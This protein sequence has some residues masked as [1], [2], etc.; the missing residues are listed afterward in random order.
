MA[1]EINTKSPLS[2][3]IPLGLCGCGCGQT[4]SLFKETDRKR[5]H[6]KGQPARFIAGHNVM[7]G[8]SNHLWKGGKSTH[9]GY[10][11][12][13]QPDHPRANK[14]TGYV[15]E[16]I[17]IAEKVLEK[18]LPPT[19]EVHHVNGNRADN[20]SGNLVICEDRA[21]H[22]LLHTRQKALF[23]C[24]NPNW[25]KCRYCKKWDAP[26]NLYFPPGI[27]SGVH[28]SCVCKNKRK[29]KKNS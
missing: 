3:T 13:L 18:L 15:L 8:E 16:H 4:T 28:V 14:R 24:G 26:T 7:K 23:A 25:R 11:T 1:P 22:F 27:T 12:I 21:Y 20:S 10:R 19:A 17:L 6:Y 2:L 29:G 9:D 5:G